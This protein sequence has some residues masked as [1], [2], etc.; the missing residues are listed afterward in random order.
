VQQ[1]ALAGEVPVGGI[2]RDPGS[3]RRFAERNR[4]RAARPREIDTSLQ[5]GAAQ[6][7]VAVGATW[8]RNGEFT[9]GSGIVDWFNVDSV[10]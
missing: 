9:H 2:R 6:V 1:V 5:Q 7:A 4:D 3:A 10:H 8:W